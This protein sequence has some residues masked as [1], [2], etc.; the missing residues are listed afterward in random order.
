VFLW[1]WVEAGRIVGQRRMLA[2]ARWRAIETNCSPIVRG[3]P[4]GTGRCAPKSANHVSHCGDDAV[5]QV[6]ATGLYGFSGTR[7]AR[8]D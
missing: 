5:Q 8:R 4:P 3:G 6:T 1:W 2:V 7:N